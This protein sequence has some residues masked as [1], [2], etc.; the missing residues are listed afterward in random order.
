MNLL[1]EPQTSTVGSASPRFAEQGFG[2]R[3]LLRASAVVA[4]VATVATMVLNRFVGPSLIVL[5]AVLGVGLWLLRRPTRSGVVT[6]G[7]VSLLDLLLHG[8]LALF[9]L[10][11]LEYP[12]GWIPGT[13]GLT[14]SVVN[15]IAAASAL[16]AGAPGPSG[17]ARAVGIAAT[18]LVCIGALASLTARLTLTEEPPQPADL[19]LAAND[20]RF[21][22]R[23]LEAEAGAVSVHMTNDDPIMHTF[24]VPE[25]DVRL[26]VPDG[27]QRRTTFEAPP[28]EY[29]F[30][31]EITLGEMRGTLVVR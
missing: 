7:A 4:I 19:R 12:K 28:G 13:I 14:A 11:I 2:W 18:A 27:T 22:D 20:N 24:V 10:P 16:R 3:S 17:A 30:R 8:P 31:D 15:V 5:I 25:L 9:L 26:A 23:R 21:S 1:A 6:I 29:E